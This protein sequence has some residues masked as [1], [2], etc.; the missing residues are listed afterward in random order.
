[1]ATPAVF[2]DLL[3]A[4]HA[5]LEGDI[6]T[7]YRSGTAVIMPDNFIM[8]LDGDRVTDPA[9]Q[10]R[11]AKEETTPRLFNSLAFLEFRK[12]DIAAEVQYKRQLLAEFTRARSRSSSP[13]AHH[14][15]HR[16]EPFVPQH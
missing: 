14:H 5:E 16:A 8:L 10:E 13:S 6:D 12:S 3:R 15:R 11:I 2:N 7:A 4:S 9:E 1:M